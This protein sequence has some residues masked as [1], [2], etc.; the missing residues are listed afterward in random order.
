MLRSE[1]TKNL[2]AVEGRISRLQLRLA[3]A[4]AWS[5]VR[6]VLLNEEKGEVRL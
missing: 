1:A 3:V 2:N 5:T 6:W 4:N